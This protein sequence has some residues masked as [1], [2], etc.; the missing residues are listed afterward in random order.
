MTAPTPATTG[1]QVGALDTVWL[2]ANALGRGSLATEDGLLRPTC[3]RLAGMLHAALDALATPPPP[4]PVAD[5]G[6]MA[7]A[8]RVLVHR[9]TD[10][11]LVPSS[12][13][14][15]LD[16]AR[17]HVLALHAETVARA[18]AAE[19]AYC[20]HDDAVWQRGYAAGLERGR[21]LTLGPITSPAARL[22]VAKG[23]ADDARIA[24][25][26]GRASAVDMAMK[27]GRVVFRSLLLLSA[28]EA[29]LTAAALTPADDAGAGGA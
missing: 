16:E 9:A 2:V 6:A 29:V 10:A 4:P 7:E 20:A 17:A 25:C 26:D 21:A 23:E 5:A 19:L 8:V 28:V 13:D 22:R 14:A 27:E 3:A 18:E 12:C 1:E 15:A 11:V 24:Y